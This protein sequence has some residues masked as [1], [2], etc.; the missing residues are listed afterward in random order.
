MESKNVVD[1]SDRLFF[2]FLKTDLLLLQLRSKNIYLNFRSSLFI[3]RSVFQGEAGE[4][5][6]LV[7]KGL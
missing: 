4:V 3:G 1:V 7:G 6:G 5:F 2:F